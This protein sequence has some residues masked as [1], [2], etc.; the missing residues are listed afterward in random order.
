MQ[1]HVKEALTTLCTFVVLALA[2]STGMVFKLIGVPSITILNFPF[3]YIWFVAG[4]WVSL[5]VCFGA[6][7][8][9]VGHLETEKEALRNDAAGTTDGAATTGQTG[10]TAPAGED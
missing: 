2:V 9:Y 8:R 1:T 10:P 3:Q 5:F 4:S 7:H 6:Y